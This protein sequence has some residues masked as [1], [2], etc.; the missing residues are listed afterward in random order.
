MARTKTKDG[1]A[2]SAD[3]APKESTRPAIVAVDQIALRAYSLYR[4][5]GCEHG[6]DLG[7]WLQAERE[8]NSSST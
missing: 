6:D 3:R 8:L 5:R 1:A 4:A 2:T 7:D